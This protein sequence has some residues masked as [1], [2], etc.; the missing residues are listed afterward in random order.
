MEMREQQ[1][2]AVLKLSEDI[3]SL[4]WGPEGSKGFNARGRIVPLISAFLTAALA[5]REEEVRK[6]I[7][8]WRTQEWEDSHMAELD[9]GVLFFPAH[10]C[11]DEL[12]ALLA[13]PAHEVKT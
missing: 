1:L 5:E 10:A 3:D 9:F 4:L 2:S 12:E 13:E 8:R 7:A 11:A 6:L